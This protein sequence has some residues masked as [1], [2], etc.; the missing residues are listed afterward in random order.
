[1]YDKLKTTQGKARYPRRKAMV[2]PVFGW[3]KEA[4]GFRRFHFKELEEGERGMGSG[5]YG[6][7]LE[8][9]ECNRVLAMR[10]PKGVGDLPKD[11]AK[12]S[13]VPCRGLSPPVDSPSRRRQL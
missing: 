7:Q 8:A 9:L 3:I 4:A 2:E 11:D 6:H 12:P 13:L 10:L 1:M 5:R